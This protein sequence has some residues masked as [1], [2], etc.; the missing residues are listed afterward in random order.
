MALE[1]ITQFTLGKTTAR[2]I[3][4][5]PTLQAR[6]T[7]GAGGKIFYKNASDVDT[8]DTEIAV[9]SRA[10]VEEV[11]WII[12]ESRSTVL[13]ENL[14]GAAEVDI[15]VTD[16]LTVGDKLTAKAEVEI[17]GD[18]N[19]DGS[20]VGF[21]GVAPVARAAKLTAKDTGT[22]DG[23]YGEPEEKVIKNNRTRIEEIEKALTD[24]G[25]L[26]SE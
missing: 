25:I 21:Y 15:S 9:G 6:I 5:S 24:V 17:D 14:T 26:K 18:L 8:G 23:T 7:N 13:V 4:A 19:H 10:T 2:L 1:S 11:V 20:K 16:D 12:S 22:V 3:N